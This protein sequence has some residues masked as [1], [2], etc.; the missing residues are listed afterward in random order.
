MIINK[1]CKSCGSDKPESAFGVL[2]V[3]VNG[4]A[5]SNVKTLCKACESANRTA[6]EKEK[7][8][9]NPDWAKQRAREKYLK[10]KESGWRQAHMKEYRAVNRS[11]INKAQQTYLATNPIAKTVASLRR[12]LYHVL[13]GTQKSAPF[14]VLLGCDRN[15][16]RAHLEGQFTSG[17]S[18]ENYGQWHVDHIQPLSAFDVM[19]PAQQ[20]A[21]CHYTNL[22][23]LWALD[24]L[25]KG[26]VRRTRPKAL[27]H[28]V[29]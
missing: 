2:N 19:D 4:K 7:R 29:S 20:R 5:Y 24:N 8:A 14:L 27:A 16:L 12:R 10:Q 11:A 28:A 9:A 18:W 1:I 22:Q 17:M 13:Q 6:A 3:R 26:G 25:T 15:A 21:A 23:P